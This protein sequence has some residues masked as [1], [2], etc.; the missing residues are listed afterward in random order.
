MDADIL[1]IFNKKHDQIVTWMKTNGVV[2]KEINSSPL[3]ER[4]VKDK[5]HGVRSKKS[6]VGLNMVGVL[7]CQRVHTAF[8]RYSIKLSLLQEIQGSSQRAYLQG[9]YP[10]RLFIAV[11]SF[12][13]TGEL[14][15]ALNMGDVV[16]VLK[17]SDPMGNPLHWFVDNGLTKGFVP[18]NILAP[19]RMNCP[20]V[21]IHP[22]SSGMEEELSNTMAPQPH[23][24]D[25][26][27]EEELLQ[28]RY[29]NIDNKV[30]YHG[31]KMTEFS[32]LVLIF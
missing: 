6:V 3:I 25:T 28:Y 22:P 8:L 27:S 32:L 1:S 9:R 7:N 2:A 13:P 24:Y 26:V 29:E 5:D 17:Q 4:S 21:L 12:V 10:D 23:R 14:E 11:E 15:V 31:I 18:C 20:A 30:F 19:M 16:A